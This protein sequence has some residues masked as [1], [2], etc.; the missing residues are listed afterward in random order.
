MNVQFGFCTADPAVIHKENYIKLGDNINCLIKDES[1]IIA[2]T[3]IVSYSKIDPVKN[4]YCYIQSWG[5]YYYIT[6]VKFITGDRAEVLCSVDALHTYR[7]AIDN[8][9]L[10]ISRIGDED[11][12]AAYINDP[13]FPMTDEPYIHN[14]LFSPNPFE[15]VTQDLNS[16]NYVLTVIGGNKAI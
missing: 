7:S 8:L 6:N 9:K 16:K 1:N 5:R 11:L 10:Y 4:N 15:N 2:P 14:Y 13:S 3:L 12:R